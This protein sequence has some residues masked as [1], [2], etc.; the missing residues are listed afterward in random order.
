[1]NT[2]TKCLEHSVIHLNVYSSSTSYTFWSVLSG[3][4]VFFALSIK[5][6]CFKLSSSG[7]HKYPC[8]LQDFLF[9]DTRKLCQFKVLLVKFKCVLFALRAHCG[10]ISL[11]AE[12]VVLCSLMV[13]VTFPKP[14]FS[15][16]Y[17]AILVLSRASGS[18]V[19]NQYLFHPSWQYFQERFSIQGQLDHFFTHGELSHCPERQR[20]FLL[21]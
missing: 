4:N 18:Y 5:K 11:L 1:M 9:L 21:C 17:L 19:E 12:V 20:C 6:L 14:V 10:H 16:M 2:C 8:R 13:Q 15:A 3:G 7:S